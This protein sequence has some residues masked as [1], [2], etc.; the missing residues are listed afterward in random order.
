MGKVR[1]SETLAQQLRPHLASE[2]DTLDDEE[3][4]IVVNIIWQSFAEEVRKLTT[5]ISY[6]PSRFFRV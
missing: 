2:F 6:D 4:E 3:L 5:D 1:T